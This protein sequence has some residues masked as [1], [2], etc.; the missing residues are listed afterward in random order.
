MRFCCCSLTIDEKEKKKQ[1]DNDR[2]I[3]KLTDTR[4]TTHRSI[5]P[6]AIPHHMGE[7]VHE[8][9]QGVAADGFDALNHAARF[10]NQL[11]NIS[12][13]PSANGP[14]ARL[15]LNALLLRHA[16]RVCEAGVH[17]QDKGRYQ[18]VM[19]RARQVFR[20]EHAARVPFRLQ[21]GHFDMA[22][23]L[24]EKVRQVPVPVPKHDLLA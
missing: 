23:Y 7:L 13:F 11:Y 20:R 21:S 4:S 16:G 2:Y 8:L 22:R 18:A 19:A 12:P 10:H 9:N 15:V 17:E 6:S 3:R 5:P 14:L 1:N 24:V